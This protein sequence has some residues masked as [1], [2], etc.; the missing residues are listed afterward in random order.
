M[1]YEL[2]DLNEEIE[3]ESNSRYARRVEFVQEDLDEEFEYDPIQAAAKWACEEFDVLVLEVVK[4]LEAGKK[5]GFSKTKRVVE[6]EQISSLCQYILDRYPAELS[7][8]KEIIKN[9]HEIVARAQVEADEKQELAD[10]YI[11]SANKTIADKKAES[12]EIETKANE[13][14]EAIIQEAGLAA[15]QIIA[16]AQRE[17]ERRVEID[18]ITMHAKERASEIIAAANETAQTIKFRASK[19]SSDLLARTHAEC[20]NQRATA[21]NAMRHANMVLS[22][23]LDEFISF[24]LGKA[25]T[26]R[27]FSRDVGTVMTNLADNIDADVNYIEE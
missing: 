7:K 23:S 12:I 26:L 15:E 19:E 5:K 17:A 14:K 18:V 21:A 6:A 24:S 11:L 16:D 13:T 8:A 9:E 4:E 10:R 22:Q 1:S 20:D 25:E 3:G 27:G 2:E